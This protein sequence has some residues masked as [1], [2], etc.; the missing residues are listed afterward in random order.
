MSADDSALALLDPVPGRPGLKPDEAGRVAAEVWGI[1]AAAE[2]LDGERDRNFLLTVTPEERY[3]LKAARAS[4][5]GERIALQLAMPVHARRQDASLRV[6]RTV[7]AIDGVHVVHRRFDERNHA[8]R[9]LRYQDGVALSA[10]GAPAPALL[11]AAG[12]FAGRLQRA[13]ADFSHPGLS[14]QD[15]PWAPQQAQRVVERAAPEIPARE[16]R[17][18]YGRVAATA[19][20]GWTELLALPAAALHNDLN[21]D[22]LLLVSG[23]PERAAPA[24]LAALDFGDAVSGPAVVEAAVTALYIA[25][26]APDPLEAAAAVVAG[27]CVERPL[28]RGEAEAFPTALALRAL[29]SAGIAAIRSASVPAATAGSYLLTSQRF[30]WRVLAAL[31]RAPQPHTRRRFLE[32]AGHGLSDVGRARPKNAAASEVSSADALLEA[33]RRR[34]SRALSVSYRDPIQVVRGEGTRL[35]DEQGRAYLDMVNNVCHVGHAHP[36]VAEAIARQARQLNT[37][38]RYLYR[39]LTDY[40]DRLLA[41]LPAPLEVVF[42]TNSGSEANDLALRIARNR[43]GRRET[44]VFEGAYHGNLTSLIEISPYKLDG[45]GGGPDPSWLHRLPLPDGFRGR[46]RDGDDD[47]PGALIRDARRRVAAAGPATLV[48]EAILGC[49][50][51]VVPPPGYLRAVYR[52]V[53]EASGIIVADEV[54]TGF[55]RIGRSF[56]AFLEVQRGPGERPPLV[57][58][59]VTLGKPAGNGH[60]LGAVVTTR[61]LATSFETGMEYFNTFGGNPVSCAAGLAVLEVLEQESLPEHAERVG[62]RLFEGLEELAGRYPTIGAVRG[63]GLFLGYELV[64]GPGSRTPATRAATALVNRLRGARILNSTDGPDA[65]VIK[66]KPPLPFSLDDADH[67]LEVL[68]RTLSETT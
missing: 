51:Q 7:P 40:A 19:E 12:R 56:W 20:A 60:P 61:E 50:G 17:E 6:P 16:D 15:F 25:G 14:S 31:D 26:R 35:F 13:L 41:T 38:T 34:F 36:R 33:R 46:F 32:A 47:F 39:Q 22:N 54:Q 11:E 57:P 3:V 67:Y 29:V 62:K 21:D 64:T 5:P 65:N 28:T 49:G 59:I 2:L 48:S 27:F 42:F 18:V 23:S 10:F 1:H 30:V 52:A 43:L 37:N 58:D 66:I 53:R 8:V 9:L 63:R 24:D 44:I 55:G 4:E 45:A 68:D